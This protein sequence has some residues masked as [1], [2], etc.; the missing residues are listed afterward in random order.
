[1]QR[2][3]SKN[4]APFLFMPINKS[5]SEIKEIILDACFSKQKNR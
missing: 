4:D 1:M 3:T 2:P 5:V